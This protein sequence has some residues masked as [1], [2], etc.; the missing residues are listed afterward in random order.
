M[1]RPTVR[2]QVAGWANCAHGSMPLLLWEQQLERIKAHTQDQPI[3]PESAFSLVAVWG[4]RTRQWQPAA[5][6]C[7][8]L[9]LGA[10]GLTI[11]CRALFIGGGGGGGDCCVL[12]MGNGKAP[13]R[14]QTSG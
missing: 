6:S 10:V 14:R 13:K 5:A 3:Y 2:P 12:P 7:T 1:V 9:G 4:D 8:G 11:V